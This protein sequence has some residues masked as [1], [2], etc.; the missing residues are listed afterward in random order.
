MQFVSRT[1]EMTEVQ[2]S[3]KGFE[4]ARKM[5]LEFFELKEGF[6]YYIEHQS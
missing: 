5:Q 6:S 3:P 2:Q 1:L 4:G